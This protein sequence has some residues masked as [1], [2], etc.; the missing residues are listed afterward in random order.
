VLVL[1][2]D[3]GVGLDSQI[4]ERIFQPFYTT[5]PPGIG[6]G[7]PVSR[8]IAVKHGGRLR[9]VANEGPGATFQLTVP[10]YKLRMA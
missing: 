9:A 6:M 10:R 3:S 4:G 7:L 1:V 2:R 5:N 8:S